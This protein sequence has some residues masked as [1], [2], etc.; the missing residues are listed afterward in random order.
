M[1]P[2]SS[3]FI[4]HDNLYVPELPE[5]EKLPGHGLMY[6]QRR[7]NTKGGMIMEIKS[8]LIVATITDFEVFCPVPEGT[9]HHILNVSLCKG[10]AVNVH[11]KNKDASNLP[12]PELSATFN[13]WAEF[14]AF[15]DLS[16]HPAQMIEE[17]L[18][19]HDLTLQR[20]QGY[21]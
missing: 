1:L 18:K 9:Y 13:S 6:L 5:K 20:T 21:T 15:D 17:W 3:G 16:F 12:G 7:R 11:W 2:V 14:K 10:G 4:L 19:E 8:P